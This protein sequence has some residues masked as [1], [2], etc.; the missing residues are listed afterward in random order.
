MLL[1]VNADEVWDFMDSTG[2][3]S[4]NK[5]KVFN[6]NSLEI[7]EALN[8]KIFPEAVVLNN[9]GEILYQGAIDSRVK[10]IGNTHFRPSNNEQF[11]K[12]ALVQLQNNQSVEVKQLPAKGWF[13]ECPKKP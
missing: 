7:A 8:M 10:E 1:K 6:E 2:L 4:I 12:N 9:N 5:P 3:F 13:I 11:L